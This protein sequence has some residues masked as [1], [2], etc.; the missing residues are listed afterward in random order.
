MPVAWAE[1]GGGATDWR[2]AKIQMVLQQQRAQ[3]LAA[4][5]MVENEDREGVTHDLW[6]S[7]RKGKP[8]VGEALEGKLRLLLNEVCSAEDL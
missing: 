4:G 8:E 6:F 2:E 5:W 3:D 7:N 1:V